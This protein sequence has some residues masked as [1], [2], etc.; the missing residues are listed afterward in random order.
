MTTKIAVRKAGTKTVKKEFTAQGAL[1]QEALQV[2]WLLKGNLKNVQLSYIRV[3]KLLAR[4]RDEKLYAALI[5]ADIETY[6]KDRLSLGRASLFRYLQVYDWIAE[7]HK[8]WLLPKPKGFIPEL[9]DA[10]DLMWIEHELAREDLPQDTKTGLQGLQ[11]K[12]LAGT[13]RSSEL[14]PYRRKANKS[15]D[16]RKAFI[17]KVRFLR[18]RG[19]QL[20]GMPPEALAHFDAAIEILKTAEAWETTPTL[21]K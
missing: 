11:K 5:H 12:A 14:G 10:K 13:L 19:A 2:T 1:A 3:G 9:N 20:V 7:F 8:A 17:A 4:V 16:A 18:K 15:E 6:A 21:P